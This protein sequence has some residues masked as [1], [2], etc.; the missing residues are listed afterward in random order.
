[1]RPIWI[2]AKP[3]RVSAGIDTKPTFPYMMKA[4]RSNLWINPRPVEGHAVHVSVKIRAHRLGNASSVRKSWPETLQAFHQ[5][6]RGE[7]IRA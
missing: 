2:R 1:M 4:Y 7:N 6:R 5:E 3:A